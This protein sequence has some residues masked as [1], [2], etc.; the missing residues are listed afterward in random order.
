MRVLQLCN[1]PPSG[2]D[3]G[4]LA[5]SAV[6]AGLLD[7]G[8]DVTIL[9]IETA[10]HP[11]TEKQF[12]AA[13][14]TVDVNAV[15]VDTRVKAI[16]ALGNFFNS[17]SY[18]IDRFYSA[19]YAAALEKMLQQKTFD[20]IHLESLYM[21]PYLEVI[22][23]YTKAPVVLRAHNV[24]Y[25][26]WQ[27]QAEVADSALKKKYFRFL[28]S[29]L[30]QYEKT[31]ITK[32][33]GIAC[34]TPEDELIFRKL[35]PA[36]PVSCIPYA[37][38]LPDKA[39]VSP[40]TNTVFHIGA[41]DWQP[42]IDGVNWLLENVWPLVIAQQPD[43]ELHLAGRNMD[44]SWQAKKTT[45]V[46]FHG[47]VPDA[48]AFMNSYSILAVPLLSG[49]GM[50]VKVAEAMATGKAI[51]S[52]ATGAEGIAAA[53]STHL[54][55]A[56]TADAFAGKLLELLRNPERAGTL[57]EAARHFAAENFGRTQITGKLLD[58]YSRL[59]ADRS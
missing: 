3:G 7:A 15:F 20:I 2:S 27:R 52:T 58:F 42:N 37:L 49:G 36:V 35:A 38:P 5:I 32:V 9:A 53:N 18:N 39:T 45:G 41:M 47:E 23:K 55:L 4:A 14:K 10:K 8:T 12:T 54:L 30:E 17:R 19:D 46:Y 28:A 48:N 24:E 40:K 13:G 29:R 31:A 51:V 1:K 33:D 34:I 6:T 44:E 57:G 56:D 25:L 50:R 16:P 26:L 11:L 22:R 59:L 43:A 21:T